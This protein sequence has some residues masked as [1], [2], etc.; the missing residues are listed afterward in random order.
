[1]NIQNKRI[2]CLAPHPDDIEFSCGASISRLIEEENE[3]WYVAFSPC[4]KSLP[5]GFRNDALYR[6]LD[7]SCALM[8]IPGSHVIKHDFP[9]REFPAYRQ[10]ILEI[11]V[12]LKKEI[13]P[14]LVFLPN[15]QDVHQDHRQIHLEGI[16]AF[17]HSCLL[18]YE[19]AWNN[20]SFQSNVHIV[21]EE[22]HLQTKVKAIQ[23]YSSQEHRV[24]SQD[25]FV[26]GQ[27]KMRGVQANA[28]YAEAF[29][30]VR[31]IVR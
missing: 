7:R 28:E 8:G 26:K 2:L 13:Q 31:W 9:V 5:E 17:K 15:S 1:M 24:Y 20:L 18:G 23:C 3:V 30:G 12:E 21:V 16:R 6:E 25:S 14:D 10:E 27:A 11:L 29:E 22:S 19:L 4:T